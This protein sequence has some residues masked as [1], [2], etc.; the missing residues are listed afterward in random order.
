MKKAYLHQKEAKPTNIHGHPKT[1][2]NEDKST[3]RNPPKKRKERK[4][5]E[6]S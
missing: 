3:H 6:K 1:K 4:K 5:R 2:I